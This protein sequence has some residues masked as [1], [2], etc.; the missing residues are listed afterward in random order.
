MLCPSASAAGMP[1]SVTCGSQIS[2]PR[3]LTASATETIPAKPGPA[4]VGNRALLGADHQRAIL[5]EPPCGPL[6]DLCRVR[7]R[8]P[9]E[10]PVPA[11]NHL[12]DAGAARDLGMLG[13]VQ[14]FAVHRDQDLRPHPA[15]HVLE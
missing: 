7:G 13:H 14:G 10:L 8:E 3:P 4:A 9:Y 15:D 11:Q 12:A 5:V 1:V 2:S 6:I